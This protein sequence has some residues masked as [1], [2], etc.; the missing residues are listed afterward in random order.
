MNIVL[1]G[2]MGTG[3]SAVG[4]RVAERLNA[5]FLDVDASI[6]KRAG[7]SV[8]QIFSEHGEPAFRDLERQVISE[9]STQDRAVIATGGG[10]L[11]DPDNRKNLERSGYLICLT[12]RT[13]TLLERLKDDVTRPLLAGENLP[14]KID[15]LMKERESV[16]ALCPM[17]IATDGKTIDQVADEIVQKVTPKWK[18]E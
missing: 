5:A 7:K 6:K 13:G 18:A 12:A 17:Q 8:A 11:M 2:F 15:R 4:R 14:M 3:K 1:T 9:L 16:Y 10:A